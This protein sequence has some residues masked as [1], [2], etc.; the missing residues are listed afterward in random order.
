MKF[1]PKCG[2]EVGDTE[3]RCPGC[4]YILFVN[5]QEANTSGPPPVNQPLSVVL[6]VVCIILII[7]VPGIGPI[8]GIVGGVQF[9]GREEVEYQRFGKTM[10]VVSLLAIAISLLCCCMSMLFGFGLFMV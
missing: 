5:H 2:R 6:M 1:C 3:E 9:L 4:D 10:L 7:L 8:V